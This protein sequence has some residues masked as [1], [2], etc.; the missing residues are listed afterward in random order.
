MRQAP[1]PL[2]YSPP[3]AS[4]LRGFRLPPQRGANRPE[5]VKDTPPP[6]FIPLAILQVETLYYRGTLGSPEKP[7][8]AMV[9]T[10]HPSSDGQAWAYRCGREFG[11]AGLSVV[12]GLAL[13]ID[14]MS[15]RGNVDDGGAYGQAAS[16]VW[17]G[18]AGPC[19]DVKEGIGVVEITDKG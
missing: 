4:G 11:E 3:P 18:D 19:R 16:E 6:A 12:S 17:R 5:G 9:G 8:V 1:S 7:L 10:R 13:G 14:A 2:H 15:R